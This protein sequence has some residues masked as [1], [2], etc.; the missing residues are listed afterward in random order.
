MAIVDRTEV[1]DANRQAILYNCDCYRSGNCERGRGR[2]LTI[3]HRATQVPTERLTP[4][5]ADFWLND[6]QRLRTRL[7]SQE[8]IE[9]PLR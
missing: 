6:H 8:G 1:N 9:L 3:E 2:Y 5:K 4:S 7:L